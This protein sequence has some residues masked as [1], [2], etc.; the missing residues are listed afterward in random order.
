[1]QVLSIYLYNYTG[2]DNITTETINY[3]LKV[4]N[5]EDLQLKCGK[6]NKYDSALTYEPYVYY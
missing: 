1:M 2:Y 3:L 6:I 4:I 5:N